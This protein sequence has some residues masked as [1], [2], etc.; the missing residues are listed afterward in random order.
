MRT[1]MLMTATDARA[2][3]MQTEVNNWLKKALNMTQ[4]EHYLVNNKNYQYRSNLFIN[5]KNK[6]DINNKIIYFDK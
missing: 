5:I 2:A 3:P 6:F 1:L 4:R